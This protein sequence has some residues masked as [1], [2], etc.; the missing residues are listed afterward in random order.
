MRSPPKS[1]SRDDLSNTFN[2]SSQMSTQDLTK[3]QGRP[4][5]LPSGDLSRGKSV[6]AEQIPSQRTPMRGH[7]EGRQVS[8][9]PRNYGSRDAPKP[10]PR[11]M[12]PRNKMMATAASMSSTGNSQTL[13]S[14][15]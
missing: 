1:Y 13:N 7:D 6:S 8:T 10:A 12:S 9:L 4:Q 2:T 14:T 3:Y 11:A 15:G 5:S